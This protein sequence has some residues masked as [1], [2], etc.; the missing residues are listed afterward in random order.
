MSS[1]SEP[2]Q[3]RNGS[4]RRDASVARVSNDAREQ[5]SRRVRTLRTT[6]N[7]WLMVE[8]RRVG[9]VIPIAA[10]SRR[11][12]PPVD[13][14][15]F[16]DIVRTLPGD[17]SRRGLLAALGGGLLTYLP[18][19]LDAEAKK[20][21]PRRKEVPA[22]IRVMPMPGLRQWFLGTGGGRLAQTFAP[23]GPGSWSGCR[24]SSE[25]TRIRTATTSCRVASGQR[26]RIAD[27]Q[28]AGV[29]RGPQSRT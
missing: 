24:R 11:G 19:A 5:E 14:Q 20:K 29:D 17:P 13:S 8:R 6:A 2:T 9:R 23:S 27:E 25:R 18:L 4:T 10:P 28:S 12:R 1:A 22:K 16:P 7:G 15:L 3:Y 21:S 26:I